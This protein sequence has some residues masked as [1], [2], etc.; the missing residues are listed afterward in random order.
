[1][2][3]Q[4]LL[5][6]VLYTRH[7]QLAGGL[8]PEEV[9]P[10][11]AS[12]ITYLLWAGNTS[13]SPWRDVWNSLLSLLRPLPDYIIIIKYFI[14]LRL[15]KVYYLFYFIPQYLI[16]VSGAGLKRVSLHLCG[17]T[18]TSSVKTPMC[19]LTVS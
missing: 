19:V 15:K 2:P 12:G 18:L 5:L 8:D 6:D 3:P 14:L 7:V 4:C 10:E 17:M 9:D 11:H 13:G 1:M 16:F